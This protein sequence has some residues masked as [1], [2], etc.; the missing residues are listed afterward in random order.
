VAFA[1]GADLVHI[2]REAMLSIGCIQA[3]KCH[4]GNCPS[5]VATHK[6][7][8][9]R[10]LVPEVAAHKVHGYIDAFRNEIAAV[11]HAA[12]YAHPCQFT[13]EDIELSSGPAQFSTLSKVFG[14]QKAGLAPPSV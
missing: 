8:L 1:L 6:W 11:T 13:M 9:Q 4:T 2:A 10:G 14:Y 5:G 3:Q 7:W 12:G